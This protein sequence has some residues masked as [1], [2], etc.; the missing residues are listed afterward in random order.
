MR[1]WLVTIGEPIPVQEGKR[2][3]LHRTGHF[4]RFLADRGH[5]VVWW[6]ST[7]D[8]F[9]KKHLFDEDTTLSMDNRL[10][11]RLLHGCDYSTNVSLA[12]FRNHRQIGRK[13]ARLAREEENRPDVIVSG[14]PTIEL[15]AESVKYAR[16][17][18]V[19]TVLDVRDYRCM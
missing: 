17:R 4:A 19:A 18:G 14:L 13:F 1:I 11:I 12:R 6:T 3:R 7:F 15:C 8:H 9:R 2:D 10:Q 16:D 5:E